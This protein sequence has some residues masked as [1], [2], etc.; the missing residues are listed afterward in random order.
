MQSD[1][2]VDLR[3]GA[4]RSRLVRTGTAPD[5]SWTYGCESYVFWQISYDPLREAWRVVDEN[6]T[7]YVFGDAASGRGT[8]DWG[9][10]WGG[11]AG[12]S[13]QPANQAA[14][15]IGWSLSVVTN[16]FGDRVVY[17]YLQD[18][19]AVTRGGRIYTQA[20]YL[21]AITGVDGTT[22]ELTY[23]PKDAAEYQD[24]HVSPPPPNGW[25][26]R[27]A[28][29]YL[30]RVDSTAPGGAALDSIVFGY[31]TEFLGTGALAKRLLTS[32]ARRSGNGLTV[33]PPLLLAYW[34]QAT[35]DGVSAA[36]V[37][38]A[39]NGALYGALRQATLAFGGT[40]S[41]TYAAPSLQYSRRTATVT[42]TASATSPR[43]DF[44]DDY[45]LATWLDSGNTLRLQAYVWAGRWLKT[46]LAPLALA[47]EAS[48]ADVQIGYGRDACALLAGAN[49]VVAAR[50]V[51][52]PG[53][54]WGDRP[55]PWRSLPAS[56]APWPS[57]AI[58]PASWARRVA[59]STVT[60]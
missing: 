54:G 38:N 56:A 6:A 14:V 17:S 31:A 23:Q 55:S 10:A 20:T 59:T 44:S 19:A 29:R 26:D 41:Y 45:V 60:G 15:A 34:G 18:V 47:S 46:D 42:S 16:R 24:P 11:W 51:A 21:A 52:N 4:Q 43:L 30:A 2:D 35:G 7:V 39:D 53:R 57:G 22:V 37:F 28:T 40:V 33:E 9:V 27:F 32:I 36:Q 8:V 49:L 13:G 3:L 5:G 25:Q 48:Y 58:S 1:R 50:D 12:P